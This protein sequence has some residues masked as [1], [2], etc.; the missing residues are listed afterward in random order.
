MFN[1]NN[2]ENHSWNRKSHSSPLKC[3]NQDPWYAVASFYFGDNNNNNTTNVATHSAW[4]TYE[5]PW[6]ILFSSWFTLNHTIYHLLR[7][8]Q[9]NVRDPL[10][11]YND[12]V[13]WQKHIC[14]TCIKVSLK[15][16]LYCTK[17]HKI[18]KIFF[19][20]SHLTIMLQYE[21]TTLFNCPFKQSK[22]KLSFEEQMQYW[23]Q[24]YPY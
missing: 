5:R 10:H 22:I 20:I 15:Y 18:G 9:F 17:T 19:L 13:L 7:S 1:I 24:F 2:D 6:T 23:N 21:N 4:L 14:I 12:L 11:D 3:L 8:V 16:L